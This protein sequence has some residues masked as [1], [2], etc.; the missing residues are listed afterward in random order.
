MALLAE[1]KQC[2]AEGWPFAFGFSVYSNFPWQTTTGEVPMPGNGDY[3]LGGHAVLAVG[4]DDDSARFIFTN[5]W[6]YGWGKSGRGSIPYEYLT[7]RGLSSDF[8]TIRTVE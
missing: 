6:G 4:Y 1:M 2:L 5:S 8:W 7:D 3:M